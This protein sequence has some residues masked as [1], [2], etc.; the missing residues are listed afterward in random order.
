MI[1]CIYV[2]YEEPKS[3]TTGNQKD[4][5]CNLSLTSDSRAAVK[6]TCMQSQLKAKFKPKFGQFSIMTYKL[7]YNMS[8][9]LER[10]NIRY[11]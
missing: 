10:Q 2:D 7:D 8:I 3:N 4:E 1:K 6:A 11:D 9:W 5:K